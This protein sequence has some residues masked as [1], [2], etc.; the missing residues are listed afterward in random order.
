MEIIEELKIAV[1]GHRPHKLGNEYDGIGPYSNKLRDLF[2]KVID[3][4]RP[5][6]M[7]SGMALGVDMLWAEK[8]IENNIRLIAA[9]PCYDQEKAWP[10]KSQERYNLI[11]SK[12]FKKIYITEGFYDKFCMQKRNIWMVDYCDLL[13]G[14]YDGSLQGGTKNCL[15]YA[16]TTKGEDILIRFNPK[17]FKFE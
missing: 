12:A 16:I 13:V 3:T 17:T 11:L 1:T 8:A 15:D 2:Q 7:I 5:T 6:E 4:L 14:V 10:L 9:I